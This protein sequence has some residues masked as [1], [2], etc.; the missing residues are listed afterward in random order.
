MVTGGRSANLDLAGVLVGHD[1]RVQVVPFGTSS[2][3]P[4]ADRH[5]SGLAVDSGTRW[6]LV[7]CG[8]GTQ[9]QVMRSP[10]KLSRLDGIFLTHLHGDHVLGLPGL[11]GTL[12]IEGRTRPLRLV[13]PVG[14]RDW[15]DVMLG[16]PILGLTFELDLT[17]LPAASDRS[18]DGHSASGPS[19]PNETNGASKVTPGRPM[20]EPDLNSII[21]VI[22]LGTTAGL[23][24]RAR[25]LH[26]RVPSYGYRFEEPTRPGH[27]DVEAARALGID[28]GPDLGR[29]QRGEAVGNIRP[30]QV[31]GPDRPGRV[32]TVMGDTAFSA[33]SV[34]LARDA[35]LLVH[36]CTY[37]ARDHDLCERWTHS[38]SADVARV[39][40]MSG[41]RQ[42]V[43][44][45]FSPR[46]DDPQKLVDEVVEYLGQ[47]SIP[48]HAAVEG[49]GVAVAA[50][51]A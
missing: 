9:Q 48:V 3:R 27:L 44:T 24:V 47:A 17:E 16:L 38:C 50:P 8:E 18:R 15:L 42:V 40:S 21:D 11:L 19:R 41:A 23:I 4:T 6:V 34:E 43:I 51:V 7:D 39:A 35:D 25:E 13:A 2:G 1:G 28:Q 31:L 30:E 46:Y 45:H 32:V 14:V 33:S 29:L 26:H 10:L 20:A 36:E 22:D 37:A 12:G 49:D 5:V